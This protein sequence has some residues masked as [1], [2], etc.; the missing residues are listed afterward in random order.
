MHGLE[1]KGYLRS[2]MEWNGTVE[3]VAA[4]IASLL[5][6]DVRWRPRK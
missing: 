1:K 6:G 3:V 2:T 4:S 5:P